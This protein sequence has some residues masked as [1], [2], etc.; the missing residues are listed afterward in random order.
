MELRW[1][2]V[3]RPSRT[4]P[5]TECSRIIWRKSQLCIKN[6]TLMYKVLIKPIWTY[7]ITLRS[8]IAKSNQVKIRGLQTNVMKK[9]LNVPW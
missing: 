4:E 6:K 2:P 3:G 5:V 1:L 7:G 9:M 8:T